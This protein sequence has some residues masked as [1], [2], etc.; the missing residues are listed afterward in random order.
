MDNGAGPRTYD[1]LARLREGD[2][3]GRAAAAVR[4]WDCEGYGSVPTDEAGAVA[5]RAV[6]VTCAGTGRSDVTEAGA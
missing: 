5:G 4:C 2:W 1:P 6:C 3:R